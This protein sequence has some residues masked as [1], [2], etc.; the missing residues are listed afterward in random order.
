MIASWGELVEIGGSFRI[1]DVIELCGC[2]LHEAAAINKTHLY[3]YENAISEDTRALL[4]IHT[5]NYRIMGFAETVPLGELVEL[6]HARHLPVVEDL[7]NRCLLD[8]SPC[9]IMNEPTVQ[10]SVKAGVDVISFSG[11]KPLG[12]P[13]AGI[14]IGKKVFIDRMKRHQLSRAVRIDKMTLAALVSTLQSY[15]DGR[16]AEELPVLSTLSAG[17]ERL[18]K[19]AETLC[20]MKAPCKGCGATAPMPNP[21]W[22]APAPSFSSARKMKNWPGPFSPRVA[23]S[24]KSSV[25]SKSPLLCHAACINNPGLYGQCKKAPAENIEF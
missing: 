8:L 3:D 13:Q 25:R 24:D 14:I 18:Q 5:S 1:P 17:G 15:R 19:R 2:R 23:I 4:K 6:G 22:A 10:S 16:A 7:G 11:D 20:Q 21:P 9:G 12:G